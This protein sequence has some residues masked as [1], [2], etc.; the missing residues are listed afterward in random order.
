M[1]KLVIFI[2]EGKSEENALYTLMRSYF[3]PDKVVFHI[4]HGD[5]LI[6]RYRKGGVV[7]EIN[8][9]VA[10]ECRKY[11]LTTDDIKRV[12]HI[13]DT[14]GL[15]I[16]DTAVKFDEKAQKAKY[17]ANAIYTNNPDSIL[18]R[19]KRRRLNIKQLIITT[20]IQDGIPYHIFYLSRNIEHALYGL[21]GHV[22]DNRKTDLAYKFSDR[23][24]YDWKAFISYIETEEI[25]LGN[26]FEESWKLI[27]NDTESLCRHS[28]ILYLFNE[29]SN[30]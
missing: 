28:N 12:I 23:F 14:D 8:E 19:N 3:R 17:T 13:A 16:P 9:I 1:N 10:Y 24:G 20:K 7:S 25:T 27:K 4:Y 2:T 18:Q 21:E 22:N 26:N 11:G 15:F 5:L 6:K 30:I 29:S